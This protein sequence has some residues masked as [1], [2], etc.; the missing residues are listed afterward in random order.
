MNAL[1]SVWAWGVT[2][3]LAGFW[4][5]TMALVIV[6]TFGW[7]R[8]HVAGPAIAL[9]ARWSLA[10]GG[11][12][13][14]VTG[15]EHLRDRRARVLICNHASALDI[16]CMAALAPPAPTAVAKAGLKWIPPVNLGFW[17]VGT[18][19]VDKG[20]EARAVQSMKRAADRVRKERLCLMISP[21]GTRSRD[22]QLAPFKSGAFHLASQAQAE[23][24]PVLIKGAHDRCP[25][26]GWHV[27]P[28]VI[29]VTVMPPLSP[30][31]DPKAQAQ[32]VHD[33]YAEW[34]SA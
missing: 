30:S 31:D 6:P 4:V 22:G 23:I 3:V 26:T 21:E 11:I 16:L 20:N 34:L 24:V 19:W 14:Q 32:E 25:P 5:S 18:I 12:R 15:A 17:L 1:R 8:Q 9:W 2:L 33:L 13:L 27:L 28:G 29:E 7:A 10:L